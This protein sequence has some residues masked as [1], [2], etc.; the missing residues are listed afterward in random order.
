MR[1]DIGPGFR[2][3]FACHAQYIVFLIAGSDKSD[4]QKIIDMAAEAWK[5][6]KGEIKKV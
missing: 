6:L 2:I 5:E 4:Q 1:I 3:Y